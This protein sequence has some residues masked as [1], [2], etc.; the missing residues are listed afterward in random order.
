MDGKRLNFF[1]EPCRIIERREIKRGVSLDW[2]S[3]L[4]SPTRAS[5]VQRNQAADQM[6]GEAQ[7]IERE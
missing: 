6:D 7:R 1:P 3:G 2:F 4:R 5:R